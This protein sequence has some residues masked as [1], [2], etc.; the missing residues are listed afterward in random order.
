MTMCSSKM[1]SMPRTVVMKLRIA[2]SMRRACGPYA[3]YPDLNGA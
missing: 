1:L 2:S 3:C